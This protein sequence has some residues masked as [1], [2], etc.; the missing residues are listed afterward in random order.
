MHH[1]SILKNDVGCYFHFTQC[2]WRQLQLLS[3]KEKYQRNKAF[4]QRLRRLLA[5]AFVPVSDVVGAFKQF[6]D[7][8][9]GDADPLL[10]YFEKTWIGEKKGRGM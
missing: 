6:S 9:N 10:D 1:V 8:F 4:Y 2:I 5:L 3:L 7:V